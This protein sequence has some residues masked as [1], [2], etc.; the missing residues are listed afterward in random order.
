MSIVTL[1]TDFG[2]KDNFV[3]VMKGVILKINPKAQIVDISHNITPQNI[4]EGAFL[5]AHSCKFF[6]KKT[7]HLVVVDPGVGSRRR[8][9]LV[10]TEEYFFA[11]PDNGVLSFA[12]KS[13]KIK[14]IIQLTN[15]RFFLKPVS[16]TF[17]GRDIFAPAAAHLSLGRRIKDFGRPLKE[18]KDLMLP[19]VRLD[20]DF[21]IG[22]II[23]IDRFGNLVTNI[24][25]DAFN[26]FIGKR[27][28]AIEFKGVLLD[29]ISGSYL[30]ADR[31]SALA[32]WDSFSHLEI[33]INQG[34]AEEFFSAKIGSKVFVKKLSFL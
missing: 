15:T 28:F 18:I 31:N 7:I 29:K 4:F 21:L 16:D 33:A 23:Y 5:L 14:K 12:L 27:N 34:N 9:I 1:L 22:E 17:H 25:K 20:K 6:P 13:R 26:D 30:E 11:G 8:P 32:I 24:T 10:Q 19:E 3:G 2:L